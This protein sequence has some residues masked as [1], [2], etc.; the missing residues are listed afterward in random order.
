MTAIVINGSPKNRGHVGTL[1]KRFGVPVIHLADGIEEA[2]LEIMK[3]DVIV[4]ATPVLWFNVS[5]L[6]KALLE[7][8]PETPHFPLEGKTAYFFAVCDEDGGQQAI[9]QMMAPLNHM[10]FK[11]PPYACM[12]Y[13][14]KMARKSE[15]EWQIRDVKALGNKL[16]LL[17]KS[18]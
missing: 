12:F 7:R 4:F 18:S 10:G 6:M 11:I 13:N 8:M 3:A 2:Y 17:N 14:T 1:C 15:G 16:R 5:A 9:N